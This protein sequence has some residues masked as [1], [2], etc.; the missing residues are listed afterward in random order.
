MADPWLIPVVILVD[1]QITDSVSVRVNGINVTDLQRSGA[2][3][4]H[5]LPLVEGGAET[6][7]VAIPVVKIVVTDSV[8]VT[9]NGIHVA[10]SSISSVMVNTILLPR[11]G[12]ARQTG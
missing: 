12:E 1:S 2:N 6:L 5:A 11:F 7:P 8:S 9:V 4:L 3:S 10:V